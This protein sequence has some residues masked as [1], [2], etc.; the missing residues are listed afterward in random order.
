[1]YFH[2]HGISVH[3]LNILLYSLFVMTANSKILDL[4]S[5][6]F[7]SWELHTLCATPKGQASNER[8]TYAIP[9]EF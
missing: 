4:G 1:M 2:I 9:S 8:F 6:V 3:V 5:D 7:T